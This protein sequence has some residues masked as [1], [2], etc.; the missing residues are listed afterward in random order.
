MVPLKKIHCLSLDNVKHQTKLLRYSN[1]LKYKNPLCSTSRKVQSQLDLTELS[2]FSFPHQT[3]TLEYTKPLNQNQNTPK[4]NYKTNLQFFAKYTIQIIHLWSVYVERRLVITG[5]S[6][7]KDLTLYKPIY[8]IGVVMVS[9]NVDTRQ[10][11]C[12]TQHILQMSNKK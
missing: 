6:F 9:E 12:S 8:V 4:P 1:Q 5:R 3:Q 11:Y 10:T 2:I 7:G